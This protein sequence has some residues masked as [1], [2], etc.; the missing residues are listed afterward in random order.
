MNTLQKD[1]KD[2]YY[3]IVDSKGKELVPTGLET[4]YSITNSGREEYT[5]IYNSTQYDII[6]YVKKYSNI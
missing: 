4:V 1:K 6:D 5:M 2:T 3:G